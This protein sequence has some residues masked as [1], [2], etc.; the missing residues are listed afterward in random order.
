GSFCPQRT[1]ASRSL[2][3]E[4]CI[5]GSS[6]E[7][8]HTNVVPKRFRWRASLGPRESGEGFDEGDVLP[9]PFGDLVRVEEL[10][11]SLLCQ[12]QPGGGGVA[13]VSGA[14]EKL[15]LGYAAEC[16]RFATLFVFEEVTGTAHAES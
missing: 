4:L 1:S 6:E 16:S 10:V 15:R 2:F 7:I 5:F 11:S 8:V 3:R 9:K 12:S 13:A 14:V